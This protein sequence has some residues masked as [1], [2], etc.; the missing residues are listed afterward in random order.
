MHF[1]SWQSFLV[2]KGPERHN[3]TLQTANVMWSWIRLDYVPGGRTRALTE[4]FADLTTSF[5][6]FLSDSP[7]RE[8]ER[9]ERP[10]LAVRPTRWT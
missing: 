2:F 9:P 8:T 7:T 3:V 6:S 4:V 1:S 10:A 5:R